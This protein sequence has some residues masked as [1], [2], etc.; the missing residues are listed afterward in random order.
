[1]NN[2]GGKKISK[3]TLLQRDF[4]TNTKLHVIA[5]QQGDFPAI[6]I[7]KKYIKGLGPLILLKPFHS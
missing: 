5:D 3:K 1:V 4:H 6:I 2:W 7:P